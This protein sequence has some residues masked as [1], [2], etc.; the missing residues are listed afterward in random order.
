MYY[1]LRLFVFLGASMV[2]CSSM[3][4]NTIRCPKGLVSEGDSVALLLMK[5]GEPISREPSYATQVTRWG[6]AIT[7][8]AGELWVL[9]MGKNQFYEF[10]T[11]ENGT[12]RSIE[13]GPR[14]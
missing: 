10:I 13:T 12:I 3:A 8:E 14:N 5:C 9:D 11:I 2:A 1:F 6:R 4:G 7:V